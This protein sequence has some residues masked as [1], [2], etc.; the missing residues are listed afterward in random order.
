MDRSPVLVFGNFRPDRSV[1]AGADNRQGNLHA[2]T[3]GLAYD[4]ESSSVSP[5]LNG[6][7]GTARIAL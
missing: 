2:I 4:V 1:G 3:R 5:P 6:P 7:R